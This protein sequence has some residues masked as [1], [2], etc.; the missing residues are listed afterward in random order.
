MS[1]SPAHHGPDR[2][3][4]GPRRH[5]SALASQGPRRNR[6][7]TQQEGERR[8]SKLCASPWA[9]PTPALP[10]DDD[11]A[12]LTAAQVEHWARHGY[13]VVD[14]VLPPD[15]VAAEAAEAIETYPDME[16]VRPL[17]PAPYYP[18]PHPWPPIPSDAAGARSG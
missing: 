2:L 5:S 16:P 13:A 11:S 14:G 1:V 17:P 4:I 7:A 10:L 12:T 6:M 8:P 15:L 18:T 9:E 3:R